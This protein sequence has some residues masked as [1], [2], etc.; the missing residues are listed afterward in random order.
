MSGVG[1]FA[2]EPDPGADTINLM[3]G[4]ALDAFFTVH[5]MIG[6]GRFDGIG[7]SVSGPRYADSAPPDTVVGVRI[8]PPDPQRCIAA[9]P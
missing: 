6:D 5:A 8:G 4:A 7:R 9:P 2:I 1:V 3:L